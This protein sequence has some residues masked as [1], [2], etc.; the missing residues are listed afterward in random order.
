MCKSCRTQEKVF[1]GK[2]Q[3]TRS[4]SRCEVNINIKIGEK[5]YGVGGPQ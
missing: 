4:R 2:C 1:G 5:W 3:E